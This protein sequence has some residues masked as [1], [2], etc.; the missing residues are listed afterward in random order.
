M[1]YAFGEAVHS[2][3][4]RKKWQAAALRFWHGAVNS[5]HWVTDGKPYLILIPLIVLLS[6]LCGIVNWDQIQTGLLEWAGIPTLT[7][8]P[9]A[10]PLPTPTP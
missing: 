6:I 7:P 4:R 8:T 2:A 3:R 9:P 1:A 10:S 5:I